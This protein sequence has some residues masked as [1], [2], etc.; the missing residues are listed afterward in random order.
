MLDERDDYHLRLLVDDG[1]EVVPVPSLVHMRHSLVIADQGT[2]FARVIREVP[3]PP[4]VPVDEHSVAASVEHIDP[5]G[6]LVLSGSL[7]ATAP[8]GT[9][10]QI[11]DWV[12][13]R[14]TEVLLDCAGAPLRAALPRRPSMV[15][16]NRSEAADVTGQAVEDEDGAWAAVDA[17][18]AS[19]AESCIITGGPRGAVG[20][21]G[22]RDWSVKVPALPDDL[23][24]GAGDAFAA[25]LAVGWVRDDPWQDRLAAAAEL[26]AASTRIIGAGVLPESWP[27]ADELGIQV[28]EGR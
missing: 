8:T 11:I 17:L 6:L 24:A 16:L 19:G 1:I 23:G 5:G 14:G 28:R 4:V 27:S 2:G 21:V 18:T 12:S 22:G 26:G 13:S 3:A 25:A 20:R 10:A 7:P 9:Y 15:K